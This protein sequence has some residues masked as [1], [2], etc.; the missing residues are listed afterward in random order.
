MRL[1][2]VDARTFSRSPIGRFF[3]GRAMVA[4]CFDDRLMGTSFVGELER[5]EMDMLLPIGHSTTVMKSFSTLLDMR[6][7]RGFPA[8]QWIDDTLQ[9]ARNTKPNLTRNVALLPT[10]FETRV[11]VEGLLRLFPSPWEQ[12][13]A[14]TLRAALRGLVRGSTRPYELEIARV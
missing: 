6:H 10:D 11:K 12:Q 3:R 4:F 14:H 8:R 7:L 1:T 13:V 2:E 9:F 5:D